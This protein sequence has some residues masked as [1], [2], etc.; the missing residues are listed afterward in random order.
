MI[1]WRFTPHAS[2]DGRG[3]QLFSGRWHSRGREILYCAMNP[4]TALLEVLVHV[5]A[6]H[7]RMLGRHRFLKIEV[8]DDTEGE[9]IELALLPGDWSRHL[10]VTRAWGD[11]WLSAG[12]T[13]VLRVP[14]VL[15]PETQNVLVN[16]RH[17][18]AS[19]VQ[20]LDAIANPLDRRLI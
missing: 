17:P 7:P 10:R 12:Q 14:S 3:G 9:H 11:R 6:A 15:V 16:P 8:P 1:V 19:R 2:L 5:G 4:A 20:L 13:A 18:R